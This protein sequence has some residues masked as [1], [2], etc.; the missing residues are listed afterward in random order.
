M[1]LTTG[2]VLGPDAHVS[3]RWVSMGSQLLIVRRLCVGS[4]LL[5]WH[6]GAMLEVCWVCRSRARCLYTEKVR[7]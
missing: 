2:M 4:G 3:V 7:R 6:V 1:R 5:Q